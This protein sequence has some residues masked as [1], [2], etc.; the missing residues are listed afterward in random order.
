MPPRARTVFGSPNRGRGLSAAAVRRLGGLE[1][2]RPEELPSSPGPSSRGEGSAAGGGAP[3]AGEAPPAT[4]CSICLE[5]FRAEEQVRRLICGHVF[6]KGCVDQW[7]T[8][9]AACPLCRVHPQT[10]EPMPTEESSQPG[11]P[12]GPDEGDPEDPDLA[13]ALRLSIQDRGGSESDRESETPGAA[14]SSGGGSERE[15]EEGEWEAEGGAGGALPE[16]EEAGWPGSLP[17]PSA[18]DGEEGGEGEAAPDLELGGTS[19]HPPESGGCGGQDPPERV[20]RRHERHLEALGLP[21]GGA[22]PAEAAGR[23]DAP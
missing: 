3:A 4:E 5:S 11:S 6:H 23:A 8:K 19:G 9:V 21:P 15:G 2:Y 17:S 18:S 7:F 20:D 10:G 14:S 16:E 22:P 12:G 1:R 13:L